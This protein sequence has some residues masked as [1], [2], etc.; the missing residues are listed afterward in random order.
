M[1]KVSRFPQPGAF[2]SHREGDDVQ[3]PELRD[4]SSNENHTRV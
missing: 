1:K 3:S 4:L 2:L